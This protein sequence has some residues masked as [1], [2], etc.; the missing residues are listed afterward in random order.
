[1]QHLGE[2]SNDMKLRLFAAILIVSQYLLPSSAAAH[3][4]NASHFDVSDDIVVE[5]TITRFAF[6][7]P[8][9]YVYFTVINDGGG[10]EEEWRCESSSA[11]TLRRAGWSSDTLAPGA[12][13]RVFGNPARR[14][15]RV[16]YANRMF[17]EGVEFVTNQPPPYANPDENENAQAAVDIDR[18][19]VLENGQPNI[20]GYWYNPYF[21]RNRPVPYLPNGGYV[22]TEAGQVAADN[23]DDRFESPALFCRPHNIIRAWGHDAHVNEIRQTD[24]AVYL[25][26]GYMDFERVI[27]LNQDEHPAI[28][29]PG[30]AGHS[31]GWWEGD[32]LVVDTTG[33]AAGVIFPRDDIMHSDQMH[34]IERFRFNPEIRELERS[35]SVEDPI[36]LAEI[37]H[38]VDH[39]KMSAVPYEPYGCEHH[40]GPSQVRFGE[41]PD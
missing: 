29:E 39:Q 15:D 41:S 8:H 23:F 33:F 38:D 13:I 24:E 4:G 18:P 3:H 7:N 32:T 34:T 27:H 1:M 21:G 5:G 37:L 20:S 31:I 26:Q 11:G 35:Y 36:Y 10:P 12:R 19:L 17:V 22:P 2:G 28:L 25:L 14:E 40:S 9:A 16:C 6:T 30:L